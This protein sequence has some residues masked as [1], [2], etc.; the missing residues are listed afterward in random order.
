MFL[1]ELEKAFKQCPVEN[2]GEVPR[3]LNLVTNSLT[4]SWNPII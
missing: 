1:D 3:N 2:I 4:I